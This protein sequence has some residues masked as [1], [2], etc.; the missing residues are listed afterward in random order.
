M[1]WEGKDLPLEVSLRG[2]VNLEGREL[3]D[4]CLFWDQE[5]DKVYLYYVGGGEK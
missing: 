3:R 5:K 2:E 4:P 1:K